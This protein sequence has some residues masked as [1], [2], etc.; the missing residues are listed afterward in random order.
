[1]FAR[2]STAFLLAL[3]LLASAG[4]LPSLGG[5]G[6]L[7]GVLPSLGGSDTSVGVPPVGMGMQSRAEGNCSS[8]QETCCNSVQDAK[9]ADVAQIL[10]GLLGVAAS[11][12]T[13][14]VGV[15]CTPVTVLAVDGISC[16]Q[17]TVC[18][19]NNNFNGLVAL[20]CTPINVNL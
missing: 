13:G 14:Q 1:M 18:C 6:T 8:G 15:T 2:L 5:L 4:V 20:G 17:Q 19:A 10:A 3:P 11:G 16:N 9:D 7:A 12:I